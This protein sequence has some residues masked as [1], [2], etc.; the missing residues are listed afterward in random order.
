MALYFAPID[1]ASNSGRFSSHIFRTSSSIV[2][3][4][5]LEAER[6]ALVSAIEFDWSP[7]GDD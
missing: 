6:K 1:A 3:S 5:F 7:L 2:G 4:T